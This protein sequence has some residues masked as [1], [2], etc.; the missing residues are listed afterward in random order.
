MRSV[1]S[2]IMYSIVYG[3]VNVV[4]VTGASH[5]IQSFIASSLRAKMTTY[6]IVL[7][8]SNSAA[9]ADDVGDGDD[10]DDDGDGYNDT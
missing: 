8:T 5:I 4:L 9:A 2:R 10:D 6:W 1:Q 7:C 3:Y